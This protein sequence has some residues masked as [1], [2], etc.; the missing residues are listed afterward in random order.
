MRRTADASALLDRSSGSHPLAGLA[1]LH[2]QWRGKRIES[3]D[4]P[5]GQLAL[6]FDL[7]KVALGWI[8]GSTGLLSGQIAW[9]F[10]ETVASGS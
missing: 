3:I 8:N 4:S 1:C 9:R 7:V 5:H 10:D 2:R 6:F